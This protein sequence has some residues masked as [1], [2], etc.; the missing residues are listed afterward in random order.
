MAGEQWTRVRSQSPFDTEEL[1]L[2]EFVPMIP[3]RSE[4]LQRLV[5]ETP[6]S[7]AEQ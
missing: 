3:D 6:A 1:C 7:E 4:P 5:S 2:R